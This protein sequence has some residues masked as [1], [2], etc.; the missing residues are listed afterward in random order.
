MSRAAQITRVLLA[1]MA[2]TSIWPT[3]LWSQT[4]AM[5][6]VEQNAPASVGSAPV[7]FQLVD[8]RSPEDS[9][10]KIYSYLITACNYGVFRLGDERQS[11]DRMKRLR[12]AVIDA[13]GD[14]LSGK[15]LKVTR[16]VAHVNVA[17]QF[18]TVAAGAALGGAV[19][20]SAASAKR[21]SPKCSRDKMAAGWFEPSELTND[22]APIIIE[23]SASMDGHAYEIRSVY[24]TESKVAFEKQLETAYDI[25][26]QKLI[27]AV[28]A[29][30]ADAS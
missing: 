18:R 1:A 17:T 29:G 5:Q 9:K 7:D 22:N 3:T 30:R 28:Q 12:L 6:G 24:S 26:N 16:Y 23:I 10:K 19:L 11:M 4:T 2:I 13:A 20:A 27:V 25:A 21:P 14:K 15:T 8:E